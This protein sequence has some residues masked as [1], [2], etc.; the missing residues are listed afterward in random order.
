MMAPFALLGTVMVLTALAAPKDG[1]MARGDGLEDQATIHM[2]KKPGQF[3]L[4][5]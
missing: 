2:H 3:D 4:F 5:R 1:G